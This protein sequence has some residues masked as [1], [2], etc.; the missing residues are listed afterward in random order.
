[1][2]VQP[3]LGL[4]PPAVPT[5]SPPVPEAMQALPRGWITL[6]SA[7][8]LVDDWVQTAAVASD[9]ALWFGTARGVSRFDGQNWTRY[10]TA[11]GL[12]G[13]DVSAIALAS[14]SSLWFATDRGL[15]R[16]ETRACLAASRVVAVSTADRR[17]LQEIAPAARIEVVPNGVDTDHYAPRPL[18]PS[19]QPA[20]VFTGRMDFRP[21]A[22]AVLWFCAEIWPRIRAEAPEARFYIVGR[23]PTPA[24]IALDGQHGVAV[25]GAVADDRPWIGQAD[26]YVLPMRFGGGI[27]FKLL[28][29]LP[30]SGLSSRP[31]WAPME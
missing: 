18:P 28:Q 12:P 8:G 29:A 23:D 31:P 20:L 9:G 21:N 24:V 30:W 22:D 25:S 6:T 14:D 4:F 19:P 15:A 11:N 17:A 7:D 10:T 27:R 3:A 13:N 26:V 2:Q 5:P 16:F 1:L